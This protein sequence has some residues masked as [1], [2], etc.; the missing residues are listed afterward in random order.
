VLA[1]FWFPVSDPQVKPFVFAGPEVEF[2]VSCTAEGAILAVTGSEDCDKTNGEIKLK[3]TDFGVTG[4]V[5]VQ[6]MAGS[7]A[8]RID[9]RYTH[10]LTD[11]NDS[12]DN[13]SIKNRA[14]AA[15]IGLGWP[16]S[17]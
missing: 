13:R 15:T 12:A 16:L 17:R 8:V 10:G 6:F 1:K 14:F 11:I 7:Q 4:G 3:S 9:A 5:G 2:K